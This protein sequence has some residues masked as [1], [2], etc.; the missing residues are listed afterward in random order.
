M[1]TDTAVRVTR[2]VIHDQS[3]HLQRSSRRLER[4]MN[5]ALV[6]LDEIKYTDHPEL[7]IDEHESTQ[8]PFRYV[9]DSNGRPI[10]P[11]VIHSIFLC[12]QSSWTDYHCR[13]CWISSSK[14]ER[15]VLEIC[16]KTLRM[17]QH[18]AGVH[19]V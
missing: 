5:I 11:E 13:V 14:T 8:M 17:E 2:T 9:I 6:S 1:T 4:N 15:R 10:M 7:R 16:Y 19:G 18:A 12:G 3:K